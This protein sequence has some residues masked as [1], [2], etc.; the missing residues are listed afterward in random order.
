MQHVTHEQQ[1]SF[2]MLR[3]A[4]RVSGGTITPGGDGEEERL[5]ARVVA[6]PIAIVGNWPKR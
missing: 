1:R 3:E 6:D 5:L 2:Q 4:L